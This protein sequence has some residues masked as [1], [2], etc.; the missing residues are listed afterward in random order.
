MSIFNRKKKD[1]E[2]VQQIKSVDDYQYDGSIY[3]RPSVREEDFID[4]SDP[5]QTSDQENVSS[6]DSAPRT[7][8][9]YSLG[10]PIDGVY[11]YMEKDWEEQGRQDAQSN[12]DLTYMESKVEI[13]KQGLQRRFELT[14]LKYN[15]MIREYTAKVNTL[16]QFGLA[17][18]LSDIEAHIETCK[19]HLMKLNEL[20]EKFH[21]N[22]PALTSMTD[23]YRRGFAF[24][25]AVI[26]QDSIKDNNYQS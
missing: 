9:D 15:K 11:M 21:K 22:E 1:A 6:E 12:P 14:R 8:L 4:T 10:M 25:V 23:S 20:E 24:G 7:T 17:G 13:I 2:N 5:N 19:E 26:A 3:Q 18:T 16:N